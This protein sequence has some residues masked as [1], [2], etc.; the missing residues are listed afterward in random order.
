MKRAIG[1]YQGEAKGVRIALAP[2]GCAEL[3]FKLDLA[4]RLSEAGHLE[5]ARDI[6]KQF[7]TVSIYARR[8]RELSQLMTR[9]A[10]KAGPEEGRK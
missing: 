2:S 3:R 7:Q 6:Q 8:I 10:S 4:S 5:E 9:F 1:R